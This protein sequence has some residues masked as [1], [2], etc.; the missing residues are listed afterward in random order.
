M[1]LCGKKANKVNFNLAYPLVFIFYLI[2][3]K[4]SLHVILVGR[5]KEIH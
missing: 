5:E 1:I 3:G 4:F 2:R